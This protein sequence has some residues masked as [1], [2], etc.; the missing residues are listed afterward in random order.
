MHLRYESEE[1]LKSIERVFPYGDWSSFPV[2]LFVLPC[3]IPDQI[4]ETEKSKADS[5]K[6]DISADMIPSKKREKLF[7]N[8]LTY[9]SLSG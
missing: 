6:V 7:K 8:F 9:I 3:L 2:S 5:C 4:A 1:Y